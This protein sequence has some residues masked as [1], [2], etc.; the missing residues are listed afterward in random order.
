MFRDVFGVISTVSAVLE[1]VVG[2]LR[3]LTNEGE[4]A[5]LHT[6]D[7]GDL[8]KDGFWCGGAFWSY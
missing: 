6:L 8:G 4:L 5:R 3:P 1:V 2:T 7:G